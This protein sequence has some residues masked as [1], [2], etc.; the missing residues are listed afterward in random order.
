MSPL[1]MWAATVCEAP[2]PTMFGIRPEMLPISASMKVSP[3]AGFSL[4]AAWS[5]ALS[6]APPQPARPSARI[7]ASRASA[8]P[9]GTLPPLRRRRGGLGGRGG[10]R[11][12]GRRGGWRRRR[13]AHDGATALAAQ[14]RQAERGDGEDCGD[15]GRDLPEHGGRA[16]R[17]EDRLAPGAPER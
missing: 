16:H 6:A 9:R 7:S 8:A 13:L 17:A 11:R 14:Q 10:R 5:I 3:Y 1:Y 15:H 2:S 4:V 12:S